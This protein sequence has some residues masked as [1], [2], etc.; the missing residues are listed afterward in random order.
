MF[1][2][3]RPSC[4]GSVAVEDPYRHNGVAPI[5]LDIVGAAQPPTSALTG[6]LSEVSAALHRT[7]QP[8]LA[9]KALAMTKTPGEAGLRRSLLVLRRKNPVSKPRS[10]LTFEYETEVN[11]PLQSRLNNGAGACHSPGVF[12]PE[13]IV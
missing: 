3:P 2:E 10:V 11:R 13:Q 12:A 1:E 5:Q 8:I 4:D 7:P 9:S 6:I